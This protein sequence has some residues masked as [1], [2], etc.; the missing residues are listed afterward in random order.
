MPFLLSSDMTHNLVRGTDGVVW[1]RPGMVNWMP[2]AGDLCPPRAT[3]SIA[4]VLPVKVFCCDPLLPPLWEAKTPSTS[5]ANLAHQLEVLCWTFWILV[6][7]LIDRSR[8]NDDVNCYLKLH[9]ELVGSRKQHLV[10]CSRWELLR[11]NF[12]YIHRIEIIPF[13][14]NGKG[15]ARYVLSNMSMVGLNS[16]QQTSVPK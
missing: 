8:E 3:R 9:G 15:E 12:K 4:K 13:G 11:D 7:G 2:V 1:N 16:C 6:L 10:D 5:N 14:P